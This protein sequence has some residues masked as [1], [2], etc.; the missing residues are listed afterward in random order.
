MK[1]SKLKSILSSLPDDAAIILTDDRQELLF[2][3]TLLGQNHIP[4][5]GQEV[6]VILPTLIQCPVCDAPLTETNTPINIEGHPSCCEE[7]IDK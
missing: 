1:V 3:L 6:W 4:F 2:D 5:L 7:C